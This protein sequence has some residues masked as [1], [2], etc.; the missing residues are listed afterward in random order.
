MTA[1]LRWRSC[2]D[3]NVAGGDGCSGLQAPVNDQMFYREGEAGATRSFLGFDHGTFGVDGACRSCARSST[4]QLNTPDLLPDS[5]P[6]CESS[7]IVICR[8]Q[9]GV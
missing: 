7:L 5:P 1:S 8:A 2:D 9:T 6:P 4:P 3:G